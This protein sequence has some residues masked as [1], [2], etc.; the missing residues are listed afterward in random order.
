MSMTTDLPLI[1]LSSLK[2]H[3]S[4][5][6]TLEK[7]QI[8]C[9][10]IGFFQVIN[11]GVSHSVIKDAIDTS[12][13]FFDMSDEEKMSFASDDI[14][15]PVRYGTN[16]TN[17]HREGYLQRSFLKLYC[18]P[19][20]HWIHMWP[21]NPSNY[22]EKMREYVVA[23]QALNQLLMDIVIKSLGLNPS[24][25]QGE[26]D[27]GMHVVLVNFYPLCSEPQS[28]SGLAPHTDHG[29]LTIA[30]QSHPGLQIKNPND[31]WVDVPLI[32]G[33][34]LV[35]LGDQMEV[36]SNGIYKSVTHRATISNNADQNRIS[37]ASFCSFALE[38]KVRPAP[39]LVDEE[40]PCLYRESSVKEYFDFVSSNGTQK[41]RFIDTLKKNLVKEHA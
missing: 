5:S 13:E 27:Q 25:I 40:H 23:V 7:I 12:M 3:S 15:K 28:L 20:S 33:A 34:L 29:L 36:M 30:L 38:E 21:S 41:I 24:Y 35:L 9:K 22:K 11:H 17:P 4:R 19:I 10:E 6:Q 16:I 26:I 32:E 8:A 1:D 14:Y 31:K 39:M 2:D 18:H 37:I